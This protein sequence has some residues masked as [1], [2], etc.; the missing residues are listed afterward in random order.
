[1]LRN[2]GKPIGVVGGQLDIVDTCTAH[3]AVEHDDVILRCLGCDES[4]HQLVGWSVRTWSA[5]FTHEERRVPSPQQGKGS[6]RL[7]REA[8][9]RWKPAQR[10]GPGSGESDEPFDQQPVHHPGDERGHLAMSPP[11]TSPSVPA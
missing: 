3:Q 2:R 5:E 11:G 6:G 8:L 7:I 9:R 10:L 4:P 1:M